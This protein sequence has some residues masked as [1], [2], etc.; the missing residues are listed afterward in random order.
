MIV[1]LNG[2]SS[3]GKTTLGKIMQEKCKDVLLLYGVDTMVQTAFPA[4]CDYPPFDEKA[5][6]LITTEKA[7][8]PHARLIVS[9]YMYPVYAAAVRFYK[10]L[11]EQGYNVIVDE[12]LFDKNRITQYFKILSGEKVYF[13]GVKPE[14]EVVIKRE[15]ERGDRIP[16]LAAGL[17][18]EVYSPLFTYDLLV[19]TGKLTP[20]E[21]AD[22]ILEYIEQNAN[23]TG[24][25]ISA[26][27]WLK[28]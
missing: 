4:K 14:K 26:K 10:M 23:P 13:I 24:F 19:D 25:T 2:T 18:D 20:E 16:G 5:I 8:R 17:Y 27:K 9:P 22:K 11:S 6:K 12:V 3:S 7:G 1:L 15:Q 21:S 28:R